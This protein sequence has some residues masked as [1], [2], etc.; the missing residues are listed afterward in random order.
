MTDGERD[1]AAA[2]GRAGSRESRLRVVTRIWLKT[3]HRIAVAG[4]AVMD[5]TVRLW[6]AKT[7]FMSG[8]LRTMSWDAAFVSE[9]HRLLGPLGDSTAGMDFVLA[10]GVISPIL[11]GAGL[12]TRL[13][14]AP[15]LLL[16]LTAQSGDHA[17]DANLFL[18]AL[19]GWYLIMGAGPISLD[20]RILPGLRTSALPL[21][22][23][24]IRAGAW[25]RRW[26]G[27]VYQLSLRLWLAAA[28]CGL[29][30][31]AIAV[32]TMTASNFSQGL[33]FGCG[34]LLA[35]G[36]ATPLASALLIATA[37]GETMMGMGQS[38]SLFGAAVFAFAG[39]FG[40]GPL[41]LDAL[42]AR[43]MRNAMRAVDGQSRIG[44][45]PHVVIVGAG[46]GGLACAT[47]LRFLPVRITL[48]DR[49]NFHLFQPLLYQAATAG[50]SPGD[51]ATPIR[52]VFRDDPNVQ[53]LRGAVSEI[54]TEGQR[55][56]MGT[57]L[58]PYDFLVLATGSSHSYFGH[59]QWAGVAPGLK[60]LEDAT[61]IRGRILDAFERAEATDDVAERDRL[62]TF[63]V[64]GGGA[65]G[66]EL[67]GALAE[68]A[69]HGLEKEFRAFDP[70]RAR[71][72][73]VQSGPCILPGFPSRLSTIA[74]HSLEMLGVEVRLGSHVEAIDAQGVTVGGT[75]IAAG[76]VLWAA[77]VTASP[78]ARWLKADAD[79]A[80]RIK[81]AAD[82]SVPGLPN[83]FAVGDTAAVAAWNGKPIPGLAPAAKQGGEYAASVIRARITGGTAPAPFRYRHRGNLATIGRKSAVA[84]FGWIMLSG[85]VAWWL[86]GLVHVFFLV[87]LRNR[88]SV[89]FNWF[90][91]YM[92]YRVGT[93]LITGAPT[94][95]QL[96]NEPTRDLSSG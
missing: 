45:W 69:H 40:S 79:S 72:I 96:G 65:T 70:A 27:P 38:Q 1:G 25:L 64:V 21:A 14:A 4:A 35:L 71:I 16:S 84:D 87:G 23:P 36:L 68:L 48:I 46:F 57:R 80:G 44:A 26:C 33:A 11:L 47:K 94:L 30:L 50:L 60:R 89:M 86:W 32:P 6:L 59:D 17:R 41:S 66:V 52:S 7:F 83:I 92:T 24:A 74:Q 93:R 90:W 3:S 15:L 73:L 95:S 56:A 49:N 22:A 20:A 31:P 85:P 81:V 42:I 13:A 67:A 58:I 53:V 43:L 75:P 34:G 88:L 82:L 55:V 76:T 12:F 5:V 2:I 61:N 62:L 77:G 28:L 91:A 9:A 51:I 37:L 39:L 18:A 29:S 10:I 19:A 63:L 78:A 54:D 8:A